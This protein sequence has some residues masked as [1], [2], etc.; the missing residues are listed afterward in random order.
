LLN[1]VKDNEEFLKQNPDLTSKSPKEVII[2]IK[3]FEYDK[4]NKDNK[5]RQYYN[6]KEDESLTDDQINEYLYLEAI[7]QLQERKEENQNQI[8]TK[9]S[10]KEDKG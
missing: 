1:S 6:L 9:L 5:I 7:G 2:A 10:P 4:D 8:P 3:R